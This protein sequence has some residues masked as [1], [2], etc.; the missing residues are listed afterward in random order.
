M[1]E[2]EILEALAEDFFQGWDVSPTG[3]GFLITTDWVLP[4]NERI[5]IHIRR[6]GDRDDLFIVTDG[7][8][9]TNYLFSQGVDL[10]RDPDSRRILGGVAQN[11]SVEISE[12]QLVKG[13]NEEEIAG[14]VRVLLEAVKE[15]SFALWHKLKS[16][17]EDV[18]H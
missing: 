2:D 6:V 4:N 1:D 18:V 15:A 12:H 7:G 13:A 11:R 14:A 3:G 10:T 9:L 17:P 16:P 5:E 8:E